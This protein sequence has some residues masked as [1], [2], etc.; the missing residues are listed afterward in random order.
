VSALGTVTPQGPIASGSPPRA[1]PTTAQPQAMPSSATISNG[2]AYR[3]GIKVLDHIA[4]FFKD[5]AAVGIRNDDRPSGI[6]DCTALLQQILLLRQAY[7]FV[8]AM[9]LH[10]SGNLRCYLHL[11]ARGR[12]LLR[13]VS[14]SWFPDHRY[15]AKTRGNKLESSLCFCHSVVPQRAD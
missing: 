11:M 3:N 10:F 8:I 1:V 2:S 7:D 6:R 15:L 5:V 13:K 14:P 12:K 4:V 9:T